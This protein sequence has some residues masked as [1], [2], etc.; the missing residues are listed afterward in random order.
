MAAC[1]SPIC[2]PK[3]EYPWRNKLILDS[4]DQIAYTR[5]VPC[6][7]CIECLRNRSREWRLRLFEEYRSVRDAKFVTLTFS[8]EDYIRLKEDVLTGPNVV[9]KRLYDT[10]Q[11]EP[12]YIA[13]VPHLRVKS[14]R[15]S[16]KQK[17]PEYDYH[18]LLG[19][20]LDK[21]ICALAIR[22][23]SERY[24][25]AYGVSLRHWL[26][27]DYG[28]QG[29]QRLH[30]HGLIFNLNPSLGTSSH[31]KFKV[32]FQKFTSLWSYGHVWLG[33][34]TDRSINYITNYITKIQDAKIF[35]SKGI[36]ASYLTKQVVNYYHNTLSPWMHSQYMAGK[37]I[38]PRYY[39]RKVYRWFERLKIRHIYERSRLGR[40]WRNKVYPT[41][42]LM[43]FN[44]YFD[45]GYL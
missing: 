1:I 30:L 3:R 10:S 21:Q 41:Y 24:R 39:M 42:E 7:H 26:I 25:K 6:G 45:L 16:V 35:V 44:K 13:T 17:F 33:W 43:L 5:L 38:L 23:F 34:C 31:G 14:R 4:A 2:I 8:P 18:P 19:K 12:R 28:H 37:M 36:G 40:T 15:F 22:R 27:T 32:N 29:T 20:Y 11:S 9:R